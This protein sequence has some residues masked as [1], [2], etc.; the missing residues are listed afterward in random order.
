MSDNNHKKKKKKTES[1]LSD[2][3]RHKKELKPP[4]L[5]IRNLSPSSW[6]DNRMPEMLWAVLVIGNMDRYNAL[7]FFRYVA[8]FV[9]N[10]PECYDITITG[11]SKFS[12]DKRTKFI[13]YLLAWSNEI[14]EV[15]RPMRLFPN[16]P[17][18]AEWKVNLDKPI[19]EDDWK[20]LSQGVTK[21]FWHQSQEA[22][23]C[24][25]IKVL[26]QILG[27]KLKFHREMSDT[28]R[29]VFEYPN[30][31]DMRH[32]RPFIRATE[33]APDVSKK[34]QSNKWAKDFWKQ[35]F[36]DT[37]CIPEEA[38]SNKIKNRQ[39]KLSQ[40]LE[41][42]RKHYF[43]ETVK[44]RN[45]LINHFFETSKTSAIDSRHEGAFGLAL[46]GLTIFI[47]I[48]FYRVPLSITGRIALR[49]LV[50]IYINFT[51]LLKKEKSE[52]RVWDDYRTYGVGQIKLIYLKLKELKK[53]VSSIELNELN[54]LVNEDKWVEFVPI[55]LGHWDSANLRK[56]SKEIG[57]KDVYDKFYNY[58][59]GYI[60]ATWG[61][62]RE[63]VYQRCVN[64]L[65][66]FHKVPIYDL[67]LM[68]SVTAD[69]QEIVNNILHCLS[70]AYP[71]FDYKIKQPNNKNKKKKK[72]FKS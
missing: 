47:E 18:I 25:W 72:N 14:N 40:E 36:D 17:S 33:I 13:E 67:P 22:T 44:V 3:K 7:A 50:E 28:V 24:R 58:T 59:S 49:S 6:I 55:N 48:I 38:V 68:L 71:K 4:L 63:S 69:A 51:Y 8:K 37:N 27:G 41:K 45:E 21:T 12:K 31:G 29:G 64:P 61:A 34:N 2:H 15:L 26:S 19:V 42:K 70:N 62:I 9:Q 53:S 46:Y 11:I 56:M 20:K 54:Y 16:L 1:D 52:P 39:K 65:H 5:Q 10:N 57:L 35:C 66:R 32:I 23:D 60:H 30:Y 43:D